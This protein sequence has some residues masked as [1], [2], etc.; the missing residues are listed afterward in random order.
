M[1]L[2]FV[3]EILLVMLD[4]EKGTLPPIP[5]LTLH[6]V[7]AGAILMDL[8]V[9]NKIDND[10][11]NVTLID[12]TPTGEACLDD[13]LAKVASS[14]DGHKTNYWLNEIADEGTVIVDQGFKSLVQRGILDEHE[15]RFLWVMKSR[16]YPTIDGTAERE[17]KLRIMN[18]LY[19]DEIPDPRDVVVI[20]LLDACNMFRALLGQ[21]EVNRVRERIDQVA[22]L[23]VIG[24]ATT[25]LIRDIQ[26][27]FVATHAPLF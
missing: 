19:S 11:E 17:V 22:R 13:A 18:I 12:S 15:K 5:Q 24:Q 9:R 14:P 21:N 25:K 4:D 27:A 26:I 2:T 3:E 10:L 20:C 16:T 1:N 8:A 6:F 7:I 23:D